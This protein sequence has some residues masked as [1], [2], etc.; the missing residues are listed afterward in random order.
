M[1]EINFSFH[2]GLFTL[3]SLQH[4]F[5][6]RPFASSPWSRSSCSFFLVWFQSKFGCIPCVCLCLLSA[7]P[8]LLSIL[9]HP[10]LWG[11]DTPVWT[12]SVVFLALWLLAGIGHWGTLRSQRKGRER[13]DVSFP[14]LSMLGHHWLLILWLGCRSFQ[15]VPFHVI[16]CFGVLVTT[17]FLVPLGL[18]MCIHHVFHL[19][20]LWCFDILGL[21]DPRKGWDCPSPNSLFLEIVKDLPGACLIGKPTNNKSSPPPPSFIR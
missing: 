7:P 21:V 3:G 10:A 4:R 13:L 18:Q 2:L 15:S 9:L 5:F 16:L 14:C 11:A 20:Y 19:L 12:T 17:S 8:V 1:K 6:G